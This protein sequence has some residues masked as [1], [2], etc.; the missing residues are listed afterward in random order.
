MNARY[1]LVS[2]PPHGDVNAVEAASH[3]G[4]SA[5]EVRMK[6]N[7][8]VPEIWFAEEDKERL[9]VT[10]S[11]FEATGLRTVLV[12]V[13]ELLE[14]GRQRPAESFVFTEEGLHG[15]CDGTEPTI[16]F[17]APAIAVVC[18][19]RNEVESMRLPSRS[20]ASR[21]S[22]WK[23][24]SPPLR[25]PDSDPAG[26]GSTPFLDLYTTQSNGPLRISIV[27][28]I[29]SFPVLPADLPHGLSAMRNLVSEWESRFEKTHMD[30]RLVDMRLRGA[31]SVVTG[32]Q[33]PS[34]VRLG[35]SYATE[36][37]ANLL[38]SLSP[39]LK[40]IG[41]ADLSSRL[42]YLTDRSLIS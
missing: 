17:D 16:A 19:P 30:H 28:E 29:T 32:K 14:V 31:S 1:L 5:A 23:R 4:L 35:F 42:A 25:S 13:D 18:R 11:E 21:L 33:L 10:F 27:Q 38:G 9:W 3:F 2:N 24:R 15:V 34:A 36:A 6:A 20:A 7:Y 8:G 40:D 37:L 22:S 26:F 41:Q 12:S 39:D